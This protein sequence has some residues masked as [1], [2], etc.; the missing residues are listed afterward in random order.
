MRV[1]IYCGGYIE[2][3]EMVRDEMGV[4]LNGHR[5]CGVRCVVGGIGHLTNHEYW[6]KLKGDPDAGMSYR[7]SAI[8]VMSWVDD[9]GIEAAI[10]LR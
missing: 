2:A 1:C 9:N 7:E 3:H 5:E 8:M 10:A 6:C 4:F